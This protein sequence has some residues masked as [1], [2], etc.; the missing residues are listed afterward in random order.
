[1][2]FI[3]LMRGKPMDKSTAR[4]QEKFLAYGVGSPSSAWSPPFLGPLFQRKR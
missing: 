4:L 3:L 1:M 2:V